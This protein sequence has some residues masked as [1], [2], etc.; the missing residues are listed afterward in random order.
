[1]KDLWPRN[2]VDR[3][4]LD[5]DI[6]VVV[7]GGGMSGI[8]TAGRLIQKGITDIRLLERGGDFGGTWYW[9]RY[10]GAACDTES[11]IYMPLLDETGYVPTQKYAGQPELQSY[12]KRLADQFEVTPRA[13]FNTKAQS[14][15][16]NEEIQRW[17]VTTE[18]GDVFRARF[19]A[20]CVGSLSQPKLPS[21]EGLADF[22]GKI[23]LNRSEEHTSELQSLMRIS[24]AVFCLKHINTLYIT[25]KYHT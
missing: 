2:P 14:L 5:E 16:W 4:P 11:Y 10:P 24:Y 9:N 21:I 1:M 13:L 7:V 25:T 6:D 19:I 23:F 12:L 20:L 3:A 15:A 17:I 18:E 22:K 8:M